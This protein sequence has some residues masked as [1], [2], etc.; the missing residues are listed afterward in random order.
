MCNSIGGLRGLMLSEISQRK[1]NTVWFHLYMESK[2]QNKGTNIPKQKQSHREQ[3]GSCRV[4]AGGG[5]RWRRLRGTNFQ[6]QNQWATVWNVQCGRRRWSIVMCY[7]C[8]W[9][10]GAGLTMEI[11]W[12]CT[13]V[14][15]HYIVYQALTQ[16]CRS[17]RIQKQTNSK[18]KRSALRLLE[19]GRGQREMRIQAGKRHRRPGVRR[20]GTGDVTDV[21]HNVTNIINTDVCSTGEV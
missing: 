12:E 20:P 4:R 14:R 15:T 16:W 21:T 8:R 3:A 11:V 2:K 1:T 9:Q 10:M 19:A 7:L 6:L 17:I 18:K 5:N 13:E